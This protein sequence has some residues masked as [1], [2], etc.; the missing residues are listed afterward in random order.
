LV[1][2]EMSKQV[3]HQTQRSVARWTISELRHLS[4]RSISY[5]HHTF[6][7]LH[8]AKVTKQWSEE[9]S[10]SVEGFREGQKVKTVK[11]VRAM[12]TPSF[13]DHVIT[14]GACRGQSRNIQSQTQL[15][16]RSVEVL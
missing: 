10:V 11:F 7:C 6:E 12:T 3:L 15:N 13:G 14:F 5:H 2:Y 4:H 1:V 9:K 8:V 16:L